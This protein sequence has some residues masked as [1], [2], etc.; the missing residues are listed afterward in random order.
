MKA[1]FAQ[2]S[3]VAFM[4]YLFYDFQPN[5]VHDTSAH[6]GRLKLQSLVADFVKA[7]CLK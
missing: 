7:L 4:F 5:S 3:N 6:V 1:T 2:L